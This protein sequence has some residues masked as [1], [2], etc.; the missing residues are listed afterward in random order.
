MQIF[1]EQV[2]LILESGHLSVMLHSSAPPTRVGGGGGGVCFS[3]HHVHCRTIKRI[4]SLKLCVEINTTD[5]QCKLKL[6]HT[7]TNQVDPALTKV[8]LSVL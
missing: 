3:V 2:V 7:L 4:Y 8:N 1:L 5:Q 6:E